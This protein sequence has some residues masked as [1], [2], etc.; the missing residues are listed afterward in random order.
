MQVVPIKIDGQKSYGS[1]VFPLCVEPTKRPSTYEVVNWVRNNKPEIETQLVKHGA[2]IFRGFE[3]NKVEDFYTFLQS[4]EWEFGS[5][6]GGGGPRKVVLGPIETSTESPPELQIP[7][8]HELAYLTTPPRALFFWCEIEPKE[9]GQT[10]L[11]LS[12]QVYEKIKERN[13]NFVKQIQAKKIRYIRIMQDKKLCQNEYQRSWQDTFGTDDQNEAA[14]RA[15]QTGAE[16]VEWIEDGD[17]ISM[18][19]FSLPLD[20]IKIDHRN[21]KPT[22]FNSIVLLHPASERGEKPRESPWQ[23]TYGDFSEIDDCD[24]RMA[25]EI[26]NNEGTM[27]QWHVGDVLLVDNMLTL[28]ARNSFVP[29]RRILATIIK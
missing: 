7:F 27:F 5:Y 3:L 23:V 12:N 24:V 14:K 22:W 13:L 15:F 17:F 25:Q 18:K 4:F 2:V 19:L 21:Q 1:G 8:H 9:K 11:L 6:L 20:G 10:P 28:H 16:K 26:M 29:P